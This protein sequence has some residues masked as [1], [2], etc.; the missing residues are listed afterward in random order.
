MD[1]GSLHG[2][3]DGVYSG[4][5]FVVM[6]KISVSQDAF[7]LGVVPIDHVY[8]ILVVISAAPIYLGSKK[9]E[10]CATIRMY[11]YIPL[12]YYLK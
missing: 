10:G 6:S 11:I 2:R 5:D 8:L 12:H 9:S 4:I 7:L 1:F 3:E